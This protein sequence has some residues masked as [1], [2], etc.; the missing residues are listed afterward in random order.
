MAQYIAQQLSVRTGRWL[1]IGDIA[2][3]Q[4]EAAAYIDRYAAPDAETRIVFYLTEFTE[5]NI[6]DRIVN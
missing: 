6:N 2:E 3:T 1:A 4:N 5:Q